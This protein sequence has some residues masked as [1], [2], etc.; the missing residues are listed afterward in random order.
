MRD[1]PLGRFGRADEVA[2]AVI[3]LLSDAS[4]LFLGQTLNPNS[5]G[6]HAVTKVIDVREAVGLVRDGTT[7][8]IGGSGAGPRAAPALHRRAGRGLH[9]RGPAP[10]PDH[11]PRRG[12]RRL[13]GSRL[14]AARP[15]RAPCAGRSAATSATSRA[16]GPWSR[17]TRSRP[18]RSRRACCR[19]SCAR[20]PPGRPGVVTAGRPRHVRRPAPDRRQAERPDDRG[21]R[22]GRH[23]AR[24]EWL[25]FQ[26]SRSTSPSSAARPPTRTAT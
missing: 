17:R 7:V 6:L 14:L 12:H 20:S 4:S 1:M 24:P 16:S 8:V 2:D 25:L 23:P 10:R 3:F 19:S 26:P 9:G 11:G 5:G 21:P 18:T 13:R 22:R 15:A